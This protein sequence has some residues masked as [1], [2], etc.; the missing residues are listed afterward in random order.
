MNDK[1]N[2]SSNLLTS[3][4][5]IIILIASVATWY[6]VY[7]D[8]K[9]TLSA[10]EKF[11]LEWAKKACDSGDAFYTINIGVYD[12]KTFFEM[13]S[14][15]YSIYEKKEYR[16]YEGTSFEKKIEPTWIM[17][18]P[19]LMGFKLSCNKEYHFV[20]ENNNFTIIGLNSLP[21]VESQLLYLYRENKQYIPFETGSKPFGSI[22]LWVRYVGV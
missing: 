4:I 11:N 20:F 22:N 13:D 9:P 21:E 10:E 17:D 7:T 14:L 16:D 12:K 2:I 6:T 15:N 18:Y 5:L 1:L 3:T 8:R 19:D